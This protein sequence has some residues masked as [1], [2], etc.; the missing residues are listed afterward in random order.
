MW[1]FGRPPLEG[2]QLV[3]SP[4]LEVVQ[5]VVVPPLE[6]VPLVALG[7]PMEVAAALV[8]A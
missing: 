7:L 6:V 3:V 1:G 4:P 2:P 5:P 8:A